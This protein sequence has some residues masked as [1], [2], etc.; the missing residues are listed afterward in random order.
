MRKISKKELD[1]IRGVTPQ[2]KPVE[3]AKPVQKAKVQP[4]PVG[5]DYS[6]AIADSS[7]ISAKAAVEAVKAGAKSAEEIKS[8]IEKG[9][10]SLTSKMDVA[11][12]KNKDKKDKMKLTFDIIRDSEK[13]ISQ[14]YVEEI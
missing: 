12:S 11:I 4:K 3:K 9:F 10:N 2:V 14:V 6:K 5:V 8:T 7:M 13:L 1:R